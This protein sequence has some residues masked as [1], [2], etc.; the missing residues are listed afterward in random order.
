MWQ[1]LLVL[2]SDGSCWPAIQSL[3]DRS[4]RTQISPRSDHLKRHCTGGGISSSIS[5]LQIHVL[6]QNSY[7]SISALIHKFGVY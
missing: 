6:I 2:L 7:L 3:Q 1:L 5:E 4:L